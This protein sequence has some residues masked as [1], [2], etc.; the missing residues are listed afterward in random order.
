MAI[1]TSGSYWPRERDILAEK[2]RIRAVLTE[3][4]D[5]DQ[6]TPEDE[7][8]L[9]RLLTGSQWLAL[10]KARVGRAQAAFIADCL[11]PCPDDKNPSAWFGERQIRLLAAILEKLS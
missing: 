2:Q 5:A 4:F 11:A 8:E 1:I 9:Q 10:V 6:T 3:T 7:A